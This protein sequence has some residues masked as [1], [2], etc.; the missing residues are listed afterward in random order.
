MFCG[1]DF[2]SVL[3]KTR[4]KKRIGIWGRGHL[5]PRN[6]VR[7]RGVFRKSIAGKDARAPRKGIRMS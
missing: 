5:C 3:R 4:C 2:Q 1:A 6:D 7:M